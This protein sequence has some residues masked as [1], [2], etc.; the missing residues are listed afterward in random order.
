MPGRVR[1]AL[2]AAAVLVVALLLA[3]LG[4]KV[5]NPEEAPDAGRPAPLFTLPHLTSDEQVS[6]ASFRIPAGAPAPRPRRPP[7]TTLRCLVIDE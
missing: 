2:Q 5:F 4:W 7:P 6:L 3:L 1:I